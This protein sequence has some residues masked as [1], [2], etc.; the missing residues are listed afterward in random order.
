VEFRGSPQDV[1]EVLLPPSF[2]RKLA[3]GLAFGEENRGRLECWRAAGEDHGPRLR[4]HHKEGSMMVHGIGVLLFAAIGGYWLLERGFTHK[5]QMKQL[6]LILGSLIIVVSILGLVCYVW[7]FSSMKTGYCPI[8]A[9][10]K[11]ASTPHAPTPAIPS[12]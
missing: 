6:G 4:L 2:L 8:G 11:G 12:R 9:M 10:G 7:S 3:G 1:I 5:G